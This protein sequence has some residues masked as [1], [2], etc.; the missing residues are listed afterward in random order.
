[1]GMRIPVRLVPVIPV[2]I[3]PRFRWDLV[4]VPVGSGPGFEGVPERWTTYRNAG[5]DHRNRTGVGKLA[6]V[7]ERGL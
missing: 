7:I 4:Q 5:P 1:M 2:G 3:G 6:Q